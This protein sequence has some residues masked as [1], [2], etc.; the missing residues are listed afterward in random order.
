MKFYVGLDVSM[1]TSAV[2]VMGEDGEIFREKTVMTCSE[3]IFEFIGS[4]QLEFELVGFESGPS[5]AWLYKELAR[6]GLPV[7]C[8]HARHAHS[9]LKAQNIKTDRN[10]SRGIAHILRTG[11]FRESHVRSEESVRRRILLNARRTLLAKRLELENHIRGSLKVLGLKIG[12]TTQRRFEASAR[13]LI[14][15]DPEVFGFIK[16][17]LDVRAV[18][19][20]QICA[21]DSKVRRIVKTDA[22]CRRFMTIPGV[23]PLTAMLNKSTVDNPHRFRKSASVGANLGLTPRKYASGEIDYNGW[24]TKT[25][26]P[27]TRSHLYEAAQVLLRRSSTRNAL[28]VWGMAIAKRGSKKRAIVAVARKLAVIMHRMWIDG[29]EF[30]PGGEI[31]A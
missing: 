29:T 8:I 24:I 9:A 23:G 31:K 21:L 27:M 19:C 15:D 13:E 17:L 11:W 28:K 5:S 30:Y 25:G 18:I 26:D 4:L 20:K 10:D 6:R 7:V 14:G 2:C 16:P 12:I 22:V 3:E 1:E